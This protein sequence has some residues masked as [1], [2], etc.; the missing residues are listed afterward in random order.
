LKQKKIK[1]EQLKQLFLS[2]KKDIDKLNK[3]EDNK[4]VIKE[5]NDKIIEIELSD[6]EIVKVKISV[7]KK[8]SNSFVNIFLISQNFKSSL[9]V[10]VLTIKLLS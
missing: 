5:E 4:N 6:G 3:K 2:G 8:Y 7:L 1:K 10:S 9:F